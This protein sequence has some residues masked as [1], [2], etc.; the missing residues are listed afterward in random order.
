MTAWDMLNNIVN[1]FPYI[2][3]ALFSLAALTGV[4]LF[5]AGF[6]RRGV[7]FIKHGFSQNFGY[8]LLS[9]LATKDDI[10]KLDSEISG[11]KT[12]ISGIKTE[13]SGMKT[14]ISGIKIEIDG[15]KSELAF[16]KVNHFGHLKNY[17]G[18]LN[19]ILL[20]RGVI[21]NEGRARLDNEI[22]CM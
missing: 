8:D 13:I 19:G 22:R 21:D 10:A 20:D 17:L 4:V 11:M 15:I 3:T 6:T 18:V 1:G 2:V 9:K 7:D 14:E 16:I 5:I 12:E